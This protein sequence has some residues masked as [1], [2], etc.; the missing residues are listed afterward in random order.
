METGR[1]GQGFAELWSRWCR[2]A[3]EGQPEEIYLWWAIADRIEKD[4]RFLESYDHRALYKELIARKIVGALPVLL[5]KWD[6]FVGHN[7]GSFEAFPGSRAI[8][9][10]S[11]VSDMLLFADRGH[12]ELLERFIAE[13]EDKLGELRPKLEEV[14][15]REPA[16]VEEPPF[17]C[18]KRAPL[19]G[20]VKPPAGFFDPPKAPEEPKAPSGDLPDVVVEV[21]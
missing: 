4:D 10:R 8:T 2:V 17:R 14:R 1:G 19:E 5:K 15:R 11:Y 12:M 20:M 3:L 21:K 9:L 16:G 6:S 13:R 7:F 18:E